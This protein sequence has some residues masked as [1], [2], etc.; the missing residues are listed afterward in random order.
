M[1]EPQWPRSRFR[2]PR[3]PAPVARQGTD[4]RRAIR[5]KQTEKET[6]KEKKER[7]SK[8]EKQSEKK[9]NQ[10]K[11]LAKSAAQRP[12]HKRGQAPRAMRCQE[13]FRLLLACKLG[14]AL[15]ER[16]QQH[17]FTLKCRGTPVSP[18]LRGRHGLLCRYYYKKN[19]ASPNPAPTTSK[20]KHTH[21]GNLTTS[22]A[23]TFCASK[24]LPFRRYALPST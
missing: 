15:L 9:N 4:K 1:R 2:Q 24:I 7:N 8:A 6:R 19:N 21:T 18:L 13:G 17:G 11:K 12:R 14:Q 10:G 5:R 20:T 16:T 22:P 23:Y 3:H